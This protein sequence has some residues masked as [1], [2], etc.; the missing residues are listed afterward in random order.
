[1]PP[2]LPQL[3]AALS[4]GDALGSALSEGDAL[5]P[6]LGPV[7]FPSLPSFSS[8]PPLPPLP[9]FPPLPS[10]PQEALGAAENEGDRDGTYDGNGLSTAIGAALGPET[11]GIAESIFVGRPLGLGEEGTLLRTAVG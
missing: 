4:E 1:M 6:A 5:G 11:L 10:L 8:L 9:S 3:G 7:P 2:P